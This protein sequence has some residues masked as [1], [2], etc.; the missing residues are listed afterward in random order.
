MGF[1]LPSLKPTY[2]ITLYS[3]VVLI[4]SIIHKLYYEHQNENT[5]GTLTRKKSIVN[6]YFAKFAWAWTTIAISVF[7]VF[8]GKKKESIKRFIIRYVIA[9][10]YWFILCRWPGVFSIIQLRYGKCEIPS[11]SDESDEPSFISST[12]FKCKRIHKGHWIGFD[13][14]G[15]VFLLVHCSLFLLEEIWPIFQKQLKIA[16]NENENN[17]SVKRQRAI[18]GACASIFS[19][20][21]VCLWFYVLWIT[22][23]HYH[24]FREKF[25][26]L[27]FPTV[28]WFVFY[29]NIWKKYLQVEDRKSVV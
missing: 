5:F 24:H 16:L 17:K 4:G 7:V 25:F 9:T 3:T 28:Y 18:K 1:N 8:S 29:Q 27:L 14:S 12:S 13:V 26:G 23:T 2:I 21:F 15:H 20:S 19:L 22:T 10:L 6:Q 11:K